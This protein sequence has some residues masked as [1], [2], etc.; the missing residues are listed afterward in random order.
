MNKNRDGIPK[1]MR[2]FVSIISLK[3][4]EITVIRVLME[5]VKKFEHCLDT[6]I[7]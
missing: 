5:F 1:D 4:V 2:D 6:F 3:I 7:F